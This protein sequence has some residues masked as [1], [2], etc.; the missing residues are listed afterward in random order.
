MLN[1]TS[2]DMMNRLVGT[3]VKINMGGPESRTGRLL[4][5]KSDF[6]VVDTE[7]DGVIYYQL[8]HVKGVSIDS[9]DEYRRRSRRVRFINTDCFKDVLKKLV[10]KRVRLNRGGPESVEGVLNNAFK[11]YI[12]VTGNDNVLFIS[13]YHLKS[14]SHVSHEHGGGK[15]SGHKKGSGKKK[16]QKSSGNNKSSGNDKKSTGN[17]RS[18]GKNR[19][20]RNRKSSSG[21]KSS[22]YWKSRDRKS[23]RK[24][25][26][27]WEAIHSA[28]ES[29]TDK[30]MHNNPY[31]DCHDS[32]KSRRS[33]RSSR[34]SKW[35]NRS[36]HSRWSSGSNRSRHSG[37][38]NRSN[39][40]R[41]RS[42]RNSRHSRGSNR[43]NRSR[44]HNRRHS[45]SS[46]HSSSTGSRHLGSYFRVNKMQ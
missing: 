38:S 26:D 14:I 3:N 20:S 37:R 19:S 10:H 1:D 16:N 28:R 11:H 25:S 17:K 46:R 27:V 45:G 22:Y 24:R 2:I 5:V 40:S 9:K 7:K 6:L 21:R 18:S 13:I 29:G 31:G 23:N 15:S 34:G 32:C 4:A 44:N 30:Y 36:R 12:E 43:S 42:S 41:R 35:S 33:R 39:R 8:A